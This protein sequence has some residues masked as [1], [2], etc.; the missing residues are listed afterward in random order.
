MSDN[1]DVGSLADYLVCG[2][3]LDDE[4]NCNEEDFLKALV[5]CVFFLP[6]EFKAYLKVVY[7]DI[8]EELEDFRN[9]QWYLQENMIMIF[10][11]F[12]QFERLIQ[13]QNS[14]L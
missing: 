11:D 14:H 7:G 2:L 12:A 1:C 10:D 13:E 8:E 9:E 3:Y 5:H 6:S 4:E